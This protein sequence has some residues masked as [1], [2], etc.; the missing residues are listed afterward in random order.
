MICAKIRGID[1]FDKRL[2]EL[3]LSSLIFMQ[4]ADLGVKSGSLVLK[5]SPAWGIEK[6]RKF[7][8][9]FCLLEL[10]NLLWVRHDVGMFRVGLVVRLA[11][12]LWRNLCSQ[13]RQFI[14]RHQPCFSL[15]FQQGCCKFQ[16]FVLIDW[17]IRIQLLER[18]GIE[19]Y[20]GV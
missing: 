8:V 9:F 19:I 10:D 1:T 16:T 14:P 2:A 4:V 15:H 18:V 17:P 11:D 13:R 20:T 5:C 6:V 12:R 3:K 7:F